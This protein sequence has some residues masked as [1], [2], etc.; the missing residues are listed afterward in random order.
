MA[1]KLPVGALDLVRSRW[2]HVRGH[3]SPLASA[4]TLTTEFSERILEQSEVET[5]K[6]ISQETAPTLIY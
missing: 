6:F 4:T 2:A 3:L 1:Q 5:L